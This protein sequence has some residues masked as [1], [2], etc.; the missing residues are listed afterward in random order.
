[1]D[2]IEKLR[3]KARGYEQGLIERAIKNEASQRQAGTARQGEYLTRLLGNDPERALKIVHQRAVDGAGNRIDEAVIRRD[4]GEMGG[5]DFVGK[6]SGQMKRGVGGFGSLGPMERMSHQFA[7]N[8]AIRRGV[9]PT[10]AV[11]G[12]IAGGAAMT[13]G[14]QQLMALMGFLQEGQAQAQRTEESPLV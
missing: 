10:L 1:M 13:E 7:T 14:A 2:F 4:M 11:G 6:Y 12:A 8:A 9:Y 3:G 5:S